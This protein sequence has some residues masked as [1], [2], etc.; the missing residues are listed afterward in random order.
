LIAYIFYPFVQI[1]QTRFK[2]RQ[3]AASRIVFFFSLALMI[4]VPVSLA[5][6]LVRE[7]DVVANDLLQ[8][9][10]E[11]E[12]LLAKPIEI[13]N[14]Q[15]HLEALIPDIR[16]SLTTLL[17]PLPE[18]ALQLLETT[19]RGTL[20]FLVVV[21]STYY[22]MTDWDKMRDA[23][24]HLAPAD[25]RHDIWR[26]YREIKAVW[27][28]YLRG[29]L[30]LMT[31]V[32][33]VFSIIWSIIGL[34]GALLLGILAGMF[35]LIPDVGPFAATAL[36]LIVALL[37]GSTWMPVSNLVFGLIVAGIYVVLINIKNIWLRPL[38]YGRSVHMHAGIV[39]VSIIAA[40]IFT[41]IIGAFIIVPVLA[42]LGVIGRYIHARLLG[43]P[44]FLDEMPGTPPDTSTLRQAQDDASLSA[45]PE[46]AA[47][48][49]AESKPRRTPV[50][51][52]SAAQKR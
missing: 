21:V 12:S 16:T 19:S 9:L 42:S 28:G 41:G 29:Q 20:W 50:R 31:I 2:L 23:M 14:L 44:A 43:L 13:A 30:T 48:P 24:I 45:S 15:I 4:A 38:I 25:Y 27:M 34:P 46:P 22:F 51:K 52:K 39:F 1:L 33:V 32:A 49:E 36:A 35:S 10:E 17:A 47:P 3:G 37:E 26:L 7:L 8:T 18:D 40:V 11:V 5:P 6:T